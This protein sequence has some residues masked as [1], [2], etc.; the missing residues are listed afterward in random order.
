MAL[1]KMKPVKY[2]LGAILAISLMG[3]QSASQKAWVRPAPLPV[4]VAAADEIVVKLQ[5]SDL[6]REGAFNI[7]FGWFGAP[8]I[9]Q[10]QE[11]LAQGDIKLDGEKVRFYIPKDGPYLLTTKDEEFSNS[12]MRVSVDANMDGNLPDTEA[13]FSSFPIRLAD[14]MFNV[15]KVDPAGTWITLAKANVPLSGLVVGK[16]C[17]DFEFWTT[18]GKKVKLADYKGKSLLLDVWSMT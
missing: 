10:K 7:T 3:C 14:K 17:P 2:A 8:N 11:E 1:R 6:K 12:S 4:P 18:Q 9:E 5:P 13:W 16:P 15:R